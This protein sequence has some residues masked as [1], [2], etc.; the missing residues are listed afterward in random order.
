M[1]SELQSNLSYL[2]YLHLLLFSLQILPSFKQGIL[3]RV[4]LKAKY[5][6]SDILP[7]QTDRFGLRFH[8]KDYSGL[9]ME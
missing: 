7:G 1:D 3:I 8:G 9:G 5:C 2:D 4:V 6:S